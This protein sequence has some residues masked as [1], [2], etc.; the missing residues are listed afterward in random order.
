MQPTPEQGAP[1]LLA[2]FAVGTITV[3]GAV[4]GVGRVHDDW[5]DVGAIL[6]VLVILALLGLA[7]AR[8]LQ[9]DSDQ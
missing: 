9:D 5:A 3:V 2:M 7:I 6:L 8:Q 4:V 1:S